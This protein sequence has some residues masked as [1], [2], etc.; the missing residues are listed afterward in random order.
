MFFRLGTIFFTFTSHETLPSMLH[1]KSY[2]FYES[3]RITPAESNLFHFQ[4]SYN[5][6][7]C[8]VNLSLTIY[9][10]LW[11]VRSFLWPKCLMTWA[12]W[13]HHHT[14]HI[15]TRRI[16]YTRFTVQGPFSSKRAGT[17]SPI[18]FSIGYVCLRSTPIEILRPNVIF[19]VDDASCST[20]QDVGI[21]GDGG[22]RIGPFLDGETSFH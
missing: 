4:T 15:A 2:L 12:Y 19:N 16:Q 5:T 7:G 20:L 18:T 21:Q 14:R 17:H 11:Q 6:C 22:E 3:F 10:L 9:C 1:I 8:I 13:I